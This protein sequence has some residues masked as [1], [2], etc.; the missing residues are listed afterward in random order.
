[1]AHFPWADLLKAVVVVL[2]LLSFAPVMTWFERKLSAWSQDRIGPNRAIIPNVRQVPVVGPLL[3]PPLDFVGRLGLLQPMADAIKMIAKEDFIPE[4]GD[5]FLHTLAPFIALVPAFITF[6]IIPFGPDIRIG[7]TVYQLQ[8]ADLNVGIIYFFAITSI[9]VY[10]TALAG[11]SSDNK[12][13]LLGALR[14]SAQMISYEISMGLAIIG[15]VMVYGSVQLDQIVA[16]QD[17]VLW[18]FV[19]RWGIVTQPLGF[20]LFFTAVYAETKRAPF[21]TPEGE[22]ELV[23]GYFTEYSGLKFGMF[24]TA[25]FVAMI[26]LG[27]LVTT[28]FLGGYLLPW[29]PASAAIHG[30]LGL[31]GWFWAIAMV[32]SFLLKTFAFILLQFQIRWTLPRFRYD[33]IMKLGWKILLPAALVNVFATGLVILW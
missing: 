14:A 31:P 15:L 20:L 24:Y 10:G 11:W 8:V 21:D 33:Q 5:R 30:F 12:F 25:E 23:A 29:V 16:G 22:S 9:A 18:G 32:L 17:Q 26:V 13:A 2:A 19:P 27:A 7:D 3:A 1:M 4:R 28:L 6:A